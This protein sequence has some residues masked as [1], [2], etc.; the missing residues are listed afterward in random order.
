MAQSLELK[1]QPDLASRVRG[2]EDDGYAYFPGAIDADQVA[3]LRK[4]MD[5]LTPIEESF[6][7]YTTPETGGFH[8]KH[9]NN[10]FNR[11]PIFLQYLDMPGVIDL[12]EATHGEDCH[13][14]GMTAWVT[15]PG[16]P[17]QRLH[18]DWLPVEVP[19]V[20]LAD[21]RVKM[22][23]FISTAHYYLND[24]YEE[25]GPT[26]FIPGSHKSGRLPNGATEWQRRTE[27]SVLCKAGDVLMF[28]CEVWHR[29]TANRSNET[30]YLLQV[31]YAQ[32]MIT[33]KF[34]PYL[35]RFQFDPDILARCTP[36]QLR[37]LGDHGRGAYD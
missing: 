15:G 8:N 27:Q 36:R 6:D 14:I 37:L 3:A 35:H 5:R 18:C 16:R 30:R 1:A 28:R 21:P 4:A 9:I 17:D 20:L 13:I 31:H 33:Q 10:S 32:R 22:P 23:V 7:Q 11:D 24:L 19:E 2:I 34:P 26:K 29:G 25:L 12:A